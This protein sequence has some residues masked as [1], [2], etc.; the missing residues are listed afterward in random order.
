MTDQQINDV[1]AWLSQGAKVMIGRH[2]TG[3]CRVKV[4]RGPFGMKAERYRCEA[5][6][7]LRLKARI[8]EVRVLN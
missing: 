8:K 2:Y 4:L 1:C 7:V 5:S 3:R 6:D